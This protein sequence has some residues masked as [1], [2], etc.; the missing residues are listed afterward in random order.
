MPM[1][2]EHDASRRRLGLYRVGYQI[3]GLTER[4]RRDSNNTRINLLFT[5]YRVI[6]RPEDCVRRRKR[7]HCLR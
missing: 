6:A 4:P 3:L 2:D 5:G 7:H 1:I